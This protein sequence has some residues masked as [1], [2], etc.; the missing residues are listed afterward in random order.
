M[1]PVKALLCLPVL[2]A[3]H[4]S[5]QDYLS[6]YLR[7]SGVNASCEEPLQKLSAKSWDDAKSRCTE[8]RFSHVT[9]ATEK[10]C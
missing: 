8:E 3:A 4:T 10:C 2:T 7:L 9:V 1:H 5:L 6:E